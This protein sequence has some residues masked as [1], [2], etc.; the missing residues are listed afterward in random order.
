ML[1]CKFWYHLHLAYVPLFGVVICYQ[2]GFDMLII[3]FYKTRV[4]CYNLLV[5][6]FQH[7]SHVIVKNLFGFIISYQ[8]SFI[9]DLL[10]SNINWSVPDWVKEKPAILVLHCLIVLMTKNTSHVIVLKYRTVA[11]KLLVT[12]I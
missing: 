1:V 6:W 5:T 4:L 11:C 3:F 2:H 10:F 9:V 8:H 7:V 12:M